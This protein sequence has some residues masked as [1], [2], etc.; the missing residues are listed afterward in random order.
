[1]SFEDVLALS[2]FAA[3]G[4]WWIVFPRSVM[5]FYSA[6]H[7]GRVNVGTASGIRVAGLLWIIFLA[8]MVLFR[9]GV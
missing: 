5:T 2:A 9:L 6:L 8:V 1:L 4:L 7:R 3:F